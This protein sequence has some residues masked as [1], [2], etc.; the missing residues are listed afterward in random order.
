MMIFLKYL[1]LNLTILLL[2]I[3]YTLTVGVM[4]KLR[5][6][7]VLLGLDF[8]DHFV[9]L[10]SLAKEQQVLFT[11]AQAKKTQEEEQEAQ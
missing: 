2:A 1:K 3:T 9:E 4:A 8:G 5:D 10:A 11:R 7:D 6:C